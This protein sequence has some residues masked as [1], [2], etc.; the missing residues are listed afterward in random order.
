[1]LDA[2]V[3]FEPD[4]TPQVALISPV[5]LRQVLLAAEA[6]TAHRD[7]EPLALLA[8]FERLQADTSCAVFMGTGLS[9]RAAAL[10][11]LRRDDEC[12][13]AIRGA[14]GYYPLERNSR[15]LLSEYHRVNGRL[16]QA[17]Q[18]LRGQL[19]IYPE[20]RDARQALEQLERQAQA[21][22]LPSLQ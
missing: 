2:I 7:E 22:G 21:P 3:E 18:A 14:I 17:M 20:D 19:R 15:R 9:I 5:A 10:L 11:E 13:V 1:M 6:V 16:R 12:L 8:D 4:R